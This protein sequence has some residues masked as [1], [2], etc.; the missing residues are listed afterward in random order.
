[1]ALDTIET[2][3]LYVGQPPMASGTMPEGRWNQTFAFKALR[4]ISEFT[5]GVSSI[6]EPGMK[7]LDRISDVTSATYLLGYYPT[8]AKWDGSYRKVEVKVAR[9]GVTVLYRHGYYS[10]KDMLAFNRRDFITKDRLRAAA[11]FRREI[12]DIRVKANAGL[13]RATNGQG[14]ELSVSLT[15]D[16]SK[17][18][19]TFAN[20]VHTGRI[21]I[22]LFLF[23]EGGDAIGSG[24][25]ELDLKLTEADYKAITAK[26]IAHS[27]TAPA[28]SGVRRVRVVV[29]DFKADLIGSVDVFVT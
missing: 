12:N 1:V 6:A 4:N 17:L 18:A 22:G 24:T 15:I 29:Y 23:N 11:G 21:T 14:D 19:L 26:G 3:G 13:S 25:Q 5:G 10:S 8:N 7:A 27:I 28:A 2:G 20:G 9:R 16:P